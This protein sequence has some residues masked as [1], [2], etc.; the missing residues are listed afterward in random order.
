MKILVLNSGSSSLKYKLFDM[1]KHKLLLAGHVDGIGLDRCIV[2]IKHDE[3]TE[4]KHHVVKDHVDA[5]MIAL[6][7]L[8]EKEII[9]EYAEIGA[10]GHR[11]V[12]GGEHYSDPTLID[13]KVIRT[14][15]LLSDLAPLHNPPNL[16][17]ILA[18]KKMLPHTPQVAVFDTAFHQTLEP[19]AY[20]YG[21]PYDLYEKYKIRKYGFHGTSHKYV[22]HQAIKLLDK[23]ESKIITCH[24]GNGASLAAVKNGKSIDTSMGFTPLEGLIMGTRTGSMD[25]AI[26]IYLARD[27]GF[28]LN[29]LDKMFNKE[30]GLLG[31]S[32][33][34][35]DV[36]DLHKASLKGNKR[37]KLSLELFAYRVAFYIGG[38]LALLGGLDTLVFTAGIGEGAWFM[39][40]AICKYLKP[41]GIVMD[42]KKNRKDEAIISKPHSKAKIYVIP[43]NE[44]LQIARETKELVGK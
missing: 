11:V 14:I 38:Y 6:K 43:T 4:E 32:G 2:R 17:G 1:I 33:L 25:P 7:S 26:P 19:H 8:K 22:A 37:A 10:V 40:K 24:L 20:L 36:R 42:D 15:R 9:K 13:E 31:V 29:E 16:A 34:T 28:K 30:S 3:K 27:K 35:Q 44:G 39:R 41:I 21:L 5:V 23:K 18:C 12:H